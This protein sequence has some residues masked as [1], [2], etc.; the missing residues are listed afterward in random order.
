MRKAGGESK[1]AAFSLQGWIQILLS[2]KIILSADTNQSVNSV[3]LVVPAF[4]AFLRRRASFLKRSNAVFISSRR[5]IGKSAVFLDLL[6]L[7][8]Q[9]WHSF[10]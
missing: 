1:F 9:F 5:S 8:R 7:L 6:I 10:L 2:F 4:T 3:G